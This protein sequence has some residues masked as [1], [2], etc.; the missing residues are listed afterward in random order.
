[1]LNAVPLAR[2]GRQMVDRHLQSRFVGEALQF[3]L[4]QADAGA[5]AAAAVSRDDQALDLGIAGLAEPLPPATDALDCELRR[6]GIDADST[7]LR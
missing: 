5:V 4:P 7:I 6:D 1:M 3:A 2:A